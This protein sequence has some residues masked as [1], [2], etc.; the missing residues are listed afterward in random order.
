MDPTPEEVYRSARKRKPSAKLL[1]S[2]AP[3][4]E[5]SIAD[6]CTLTMEEAVAVKGF[7][8][9]RRCLNGKV[10]AK[11]GASG[12]LAKEMAAKYEVLETRGSSSIV[13]NR[14][15]DQSNT[16]GLEEPRGLPPLLNEFMAAC[17]SIPYE[18]RTALLGPVQ[19]RA[20]LNGDPLA[21]AE[22][23]EDESPYYAVL[24]K[25]RWV[26]SLRC[27]VAGD[28][29]MRGSGK[30][31]VVSEAKFDD[32]EAMVRVRFVCVCHEKPKGPPKR[33][34][35]LL[36]DVEPIV[37][38]QGCPHTVSVYSP[39]S[40][41][42]A[43]AI[44]VIRNRHTCHVAH[45]ILPLHDSVKKA[46]GDAAVRGSEYNITLR[47]TWGEINNIKAAY[48]AKMEAIR[49][50]GTPAREQ[51]IIDA[52]GGT[53]FTPGRGNVGTAGRKANV[54]NFGVMCAKS[55]MVQEITAFDPFALTENRDPVSL[56]SGRQI[57]ELTQWAS[58]TDAYVRSQEANKL[59]GAALKSQVARLLKA[60]GSGGELP[61]EDFAGADAA[62]P[63][64][65]AEDLDASDNNYN[66]NEDGDDDDD[67][68]EHSPYMSVSIRGRPLNRSLQVAT[69]REEAAVYE[70]GNVAEFF[71]G[72]AAP[73][74]GESPPRRAAREAPVD[75]APSDDAPA[76]IDSLLCLSGCTARTLQA[77]A[78]L[79]GNRI[80]AYRFEVLKNDQWKAA[81]RATAT[82][83]GMS[84]LELLESSVTT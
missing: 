74:A 22:P 20:L 69:C 55:A 44:V 82:G 38:D 56:M 63:F 25:D 15:Q 65:R 47:S 14:G 17:S 83:C 34:P 16:A 79:V 58:D 68:D 60:R 31:L 12:R 35:A 27:Y 78:G 33:A 4:E 67:D 29:A 62:A 32:E 51:P 73:R 30:Q 59:S 77:L 52:Q 43:W 13:F 36:P 21:L 28:P 48:Y 8:F 1:A 64:T 9:L 46:V 23:N 84:V 53:S 80:T 75:F 81:A 18:R 5:S 11:A 37:Y 10:P 49:T 50:T 24:P 6:K 41:A 42:C 76:V 19:A 54:A 7:F 72:Q 39:A 61:V 26:D 66:N 57:V 2:Q 40:N 70:F 71:E 45:R 3:S